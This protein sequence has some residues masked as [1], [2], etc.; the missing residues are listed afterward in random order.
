MVVQSDS[1]LAAIRA[2]ANAGGRVFGS[3]FN[4]AWFST[5][6]DFAKAA[7]WTPGP[8]YGGVAVS[9]VSIDVVSNPKGEAFSVWHLTGMRPRDLQLPDDRVRSAG[10]GCGQ[11]IDCGNC[12]TVQICGFDGHPGQCGQPQVIP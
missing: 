1:D 8:Y 2:Y 10:D 5:N 6:G 3:D 12:P 7:D 9:P 4:D 11:A